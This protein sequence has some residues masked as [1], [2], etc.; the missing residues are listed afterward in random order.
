M[1][2]CLL[3]LVLHHPPRWIQA[4]GRFPRT[5]SWQMKYLINQEALIPSLEADSFYEMLLKC[6]STRPGNYPVLQETF[7]GW[8]LSGRTAATTTQ[9]DPH[10]TFLLRQ[11]NGLEHNLNRFWEVEPMEQSTMTAEHQACEQHFMTHTKPSNKM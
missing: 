9:N 5:S 3:L 11:E 10:H 7:L 1:A 6:R 4:P 8:T 2:S